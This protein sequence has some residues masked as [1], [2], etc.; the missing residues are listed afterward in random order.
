MGLP[1]SREDIT[2]LQHRTEGWIA[3]LQLAA[4]SLRKREDLSTFVKEF[5]GSHRFVLDYVQQ[6]ILAWLPAP[7]QDFLLQTSILTR[8]NAA[9]YQVVTAG[10]TQ[11]ESQQMLEELERANLFVVPLDEKRQLYRYHALFQQPLLPRLTP[12]PPESIP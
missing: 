1:L 9:V 6:D 2:A 4:L 3:G 11:K 7:L 10:T 8:L 5:A 12:S